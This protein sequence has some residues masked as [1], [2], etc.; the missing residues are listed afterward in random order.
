MELASDDPLLNAWQKTL[1]RK[2]DAA[3][4]F[5]TSGE[6]SRT[7]AQI[8]S[9]AQT[10]ARK[11]DMFDPGSVLAI[12][13]GNPPDWAALFL[14]CLRKQMVV[15]PLGQSMSDAERDAALKV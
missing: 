1:A 6:I 13:I 7:F 4:I 5:D 12:Q 2:G 8:E 3:A 11:I 10:F 9:D 14:A 15:F